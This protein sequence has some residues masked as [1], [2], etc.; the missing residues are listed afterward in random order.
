VPQI[1][2]PLIFMSGTNARLE[3][4]IAI[5]EGTDEIAPPDRKTQQRTGEMIARAASGSYRPKRPVSV[6]K[7][8]RH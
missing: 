6:Q 4:L 7:K 5:F 2:K 8:S 1:Q 3:E